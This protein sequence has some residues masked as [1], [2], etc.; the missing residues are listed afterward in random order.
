MLNFHLE[1]ER[2]ISGVRMNAPPRWL[3]R[4]P[5]ARDIV[6]GTGEF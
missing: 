5:C 3:H 2:I 4:P 1:I 6:A